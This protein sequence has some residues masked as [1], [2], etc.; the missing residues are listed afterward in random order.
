MPKTKTD[1]LGRQYSVEKPS[2]HQAID[3]L[4]KS[5]EQGTYHA[6][7]DDSE[8]ERETIARIRNG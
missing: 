4:A 7:M 8:W 3:R 2:N 6:L 5:I 1:H